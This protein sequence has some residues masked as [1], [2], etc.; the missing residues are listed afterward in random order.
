MEAVRMAFALITLVGMIGLVKP[1]ARLKMAHRW[2]A[3]A[4]F[5]VGMVGFAAVNPT[6]PD[7]ATAQS[8]S[9]HET[10]MP[11]AKAD[12]P[13]TIEEARE[14][15]YEDARISWA[16]NKAGPPSAAKVAL[17]IKMVDNEA[18]TDPELADP[19]IRLA[20]YKVAITVV[21]CDNPTPC[22]YK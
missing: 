5:A 17:A 9:L 19:E 16:D 12:Q 15:A 11:G 10:S 18:K 7:A 20:N 1:I 3:F 14:M 6:L 21:H 22:G 2:H 13:A 4:W 8:G